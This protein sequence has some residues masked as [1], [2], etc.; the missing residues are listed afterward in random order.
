M[1]ERRP[2]VKGTRKVK[3]VMGEFKRGSLRS[4]SARGPKVKERQQAIAIALSE[5]RKADKRGR[6]N[7]RKA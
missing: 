4:G 3:K 2:K 5:Q 7:A 6:K 1:A